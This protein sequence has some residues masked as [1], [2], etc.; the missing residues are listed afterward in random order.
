MKHDLSD[1]KKS[2]YFYADYHGQSGNDEFHAVTAHFI[3]EITH[4]RIN[5]LNKTHN[6]STVFNFLTDIITYRTESK[7]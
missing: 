1:G 2:V 6:D 5:G 3:C 4:I 7:L